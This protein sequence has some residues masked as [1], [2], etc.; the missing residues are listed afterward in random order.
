[1]WKVNGKSQCH[2]FYMHSSNRSNIGKILLVP[3]PQHSLSKAINIYILDF[4]VTCRQQIEALYTIFHIKREVK[5]DEI[6][7]LDNAYGMRGRGSITTDIMNLGLVGV[8][9]ITRRKFAIGSKLETA[10]QTC[11]IVCILIGGAQRLNSAP[12]VSAT[13]QQQ[14]GQKVLREVLRKRQRQHPVLLAC[15]GIGQA[16]GVSAQENCIPLF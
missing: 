7:L 10:N 12:Q 5:L 13:D 14:N 4:L 15:F 8:D 11:R 1:M 6:A 16:P 3:I 9:D 2:W